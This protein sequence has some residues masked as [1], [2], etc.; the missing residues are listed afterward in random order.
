LA[1]VIS[2]SERIEPPPHPLSRMKGGLLRYRRSERRIEKRG[3]RC[4]HFTAREKCL[5]ERQYVCKRRSAVCGLPIALCAPRKFVDALSAGCRSRPRARL[6]EQPRD[7]RLVLLRGLLLTASGQLHLAR[8]LEQL[9]SERL[10]LP[11]L[12]LPADLLDRSGCGWRT[13]SRRRR[14]SNG[15]RLL[16]RHSRG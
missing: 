2:G 10:V 8:F 4:E 15:C 14:G 12:R 3:S 16:R 6:A 5:I 13:R 11:G 9:L 7:P 1:R